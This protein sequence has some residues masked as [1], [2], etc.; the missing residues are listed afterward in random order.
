MGINLRTG[1]DELTKTDANLHASVHN[2]SLCTMHCSRGL[3]YEDLKTSH[4]F[5]PFPHHTHTPPHTNLYTY[6]YI[7][8]LSG[9]EKATIYHFI[10]RWYNGRYAQSTTAHRRGKK[11]KT[12]MDQWKASHWNK[13]WISK[14]E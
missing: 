9:W 3:G 7:H 8:P 13:S 4:S 12:V 14:G 6:P 11:H 10:Q 2:L 5:L 1:T